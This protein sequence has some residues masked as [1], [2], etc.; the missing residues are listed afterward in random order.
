MNTRAHSL[1]STRLEQLAT[2]LQAMADPQELMRCIFETAGARAAIGTSGQLTGSVMLDLAVRAGLR[3]RVFTLDTLRLFPETYEL[4]RTLERKYD[5]D[6]EWYRPDQQ[7]VRKMVERHGEFLFFDSKGKQEYCCEIRKVNPNLKA[8]GT[9]DVWL[10]GLRADQS[11][12]RREVPRIEMIDHTDEDGTTRTILKVAPLVDWTET[13]LREYCD[14]YR[15]PIHPLLV[16]WDPQGWRYES[17]GC[18]ICTTPSGPHEPRRSGRWRW[19]SAANAEGADHKECGIHLAPPA[20][21][22]TQ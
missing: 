22:R 12:S 19:Q 7:A 9:L 11:E 6:F 17:I 16:F 10:T 1:T 18:T 13:R 4:L 15:V 2:T 20:A 5:I 14:R 8:L 3:P 21:D